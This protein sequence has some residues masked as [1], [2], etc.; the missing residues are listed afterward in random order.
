MALIKQVPVQEVNI[1]QRH[2]DFVAVLRCSETI[3]D[4]SDSDSFTT[5]S[6][7]DDISDQELFRD[8]IDPGFVQNLS[9]MEYYFNFDAYGVF[10]GAASQLITYSWQIKPNGEADWTDIVSSSTVTVTATGAGTESESAID[11][12]FFETPV[13]ARFYLRLIATATKDASC[14][15]YYATFAESSGSSIRV[16][17]KLD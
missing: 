17:G 1:K 6:F 3:K 16:V 8:S 13:S 5:P 9:W 10:T 7:T 12:G 11:H 2:F 15:S 4:D 14:S